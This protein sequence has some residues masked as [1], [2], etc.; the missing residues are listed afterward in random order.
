MLHYK[1][2]QNVPLKLLVSDLIITIS[3]HKIKLKVTMGHSV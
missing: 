3:F 2:K 1:L